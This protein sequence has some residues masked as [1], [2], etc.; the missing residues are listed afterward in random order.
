MR[1]REVIKWWK[2]AGEPRLLAVLTVR[3][4]PVVLHYRRGR[5][6][7]AVSFVKELAESLAP[8]ILPRPY[9]GTIRCRITPIRGVLML[10]GIGYALDST[11]LMNHLARRK[12]LEALGFRCEEGRIVTE[13]REVNALRPGLTVFVDDVET[14]KIVGRKRE[15]A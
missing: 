3:G 15:I 8:K 11:P 7:G 6:I 10:I 5:L 1:H 13:E 12:L 2:E 14:G 9:S 4:A